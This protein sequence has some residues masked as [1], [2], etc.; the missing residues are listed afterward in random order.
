MKDGKQKA[1]FKSLLTE[2]ESDNNLKNS[3]L[4][5]FLNNIC[6]SPDKFNKYSNVSGKVA[7]KTVKEL[8]KLINKTQ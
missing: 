1:E 7:C 4:R 8:I 6:S 3:E 5:K 2:V